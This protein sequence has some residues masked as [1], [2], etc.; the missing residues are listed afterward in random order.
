MTNNSTERT[1]TESRKKRA[2]ITRTSIMR[3]AEKLFAK[4]GI[5][6]VSV[7]AIIKEAGQKNESAL[8]YH[9]KNRQGL[10]E[11]INIFRQTQVDKKRGE[12]YLELLSR[13]PTPTLREVCSLLVEPVFL[14]AKSDPGIR[15]WLK[16]FSQGYASWT[17]A[18]LKRNWSSLGNNTKETAKILRS[19]MD[20]I[21]S[22]VADLRVLNAMRFIAL[23][24][25]QQAS[26]K[27][28]FRNEDSELFYQVL[29]D[30]ITA[31]LCAD[32]SAET[33]KAVTAKEK[34]KNQ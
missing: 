8:Q 28:A 17:S 25:S 29:L 31:S 27:N 2:D 33:Q 21:N 23:S 18:A 16:A 34:S 14:L 3:A 11:A 32:M 1:D 13:T 24:L 9:F 4:N 22:T 19:H 12:L 20:H 7:R 30:G 6:N 5:E 10:I 15:Q 26:E